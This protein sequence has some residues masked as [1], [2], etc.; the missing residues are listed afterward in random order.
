MNVTIRNMTVQFAE[1]IDPRIRL[2]REGHAPVEQSER[3]YRDAAGSYGTIHPEAGS[4][5]YRM[6]ITDLRFLWGRLPPGRFGLQLIYPARGVR[7]Q[8]ATAP[9]P[10]VSSPIFWFEVRRASLD[11]AE[12]SSSPVGVGII[13][14]SSRESA[15]IEN[16]TRKDVK[17]DGYLGDQDSFLPAISWQSWIPGL[18]W[19]ELEDAP[20]H[21]CGTGR[22][23]RTLRPGENLELDL[24]PLEADGIHRYTVLAT[25]GD[26]DSSRPT[27]VCSRAVLVDNFD[28]QWDKARSGRKR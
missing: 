21:S 2:I 28:I 9:T 1:G 18:G 8:G 24:P 7:E 5:L 27:F 26:P 17:I 25:G 4:A 15:R 14:P 16:R 23:V 12:R 19:S 10:E 6:D 11:E 22:I 20:R 13:L 3:D